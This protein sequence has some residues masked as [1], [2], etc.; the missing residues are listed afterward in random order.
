MYFCIFVLVLFSIMAFF[1]K[2]KIENEVDFIKKINKNFRLKYIILFMLLIGMILYIIS[3]ILSLTVKGIWINLV[4]VFF[5]F[6]LVSVE[7]AIIFNRI[8]IYSNFSKDEIVNQYI[9]F[10]AVKE[11]S[12]FKYVE[13][14]TWFSRWNHK[15]FRSKDND[16]EIDRLIIKLELLLRPYDNGLCLASHHKNSF[17]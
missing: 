5:A 8:D 10:F 6:P 17:L 1:Q 2:R 3:Y 9:S 15:Y 11:M 16:Q 4:T 7:W 14:I 13:I 12:S